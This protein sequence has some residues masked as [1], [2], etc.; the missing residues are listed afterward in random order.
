MPSRDPMHLQPE[1]RIL[2][3]RWLDAC[4]KAGIDVLTTC[5]YRSQAEQDQL[6]AQGRTAPGAKVTWTRTSR[7]SETINGRPAS[8]AWDFVVLV[9]G[10]AVWNAKH[11]HWAIAGSIAEDLGLDWGG[12]WARNKDFP[13]IQLRR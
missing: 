11:P 2:H 7:H 9:A 10:K 13:H 8:T 4:G 6:W 1:L 3:A 5:T 12:A